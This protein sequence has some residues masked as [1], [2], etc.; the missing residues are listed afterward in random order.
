MRTSGSI[1]GALVL[2]LFGPLVWAA[3]FFLSYAGHASLCEAGGRLPAGPAALPWLFVT[4]SVLA[5]AALGLAALWP[6]PL[7]GILAGSADAA[8]M[9]FL[10]RLMRLLI[11]LAGF[12]LNWSVMAMIVLPTC[13]PLR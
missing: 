13:S 4:A 11:L 7:S 6:G 8:E 2:V 12:G 3:H 9:A 1:A 5:Y 10:V